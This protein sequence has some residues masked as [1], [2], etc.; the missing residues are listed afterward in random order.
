MVAAVC[1]LSHEES[2][3]LRGESASCVFIPEGWLPEESVLGLRYVDDLL[4]LSKCLCHSCL[5]RLVDSIYSVSFEINTEA[6]EQTWVD[7]VSKV[8]AETGAIFWIPKNANRPWLQNL[9]GKT[10][11]KYAPYLGRLQTRFGVLRGMLLGRAARLREL[12]LPPDHIIVYMLEELQELPL[13]GYPLSFLRA[14]VHSFPGHCHDFVVLRR[15][16]RDLERKARAH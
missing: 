11:E 12:E 3:F 1:L 13:E 14:L 9:H 8:N 7:V 6:L 5:K 2:L 10:K 4:L 16:L 15:A